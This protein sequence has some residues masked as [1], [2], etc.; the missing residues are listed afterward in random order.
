MGHCKVAGAIARRERRIAILDEPLQGNDGALQAWN[1]PLQLD[2]GSL[3]ARNP[4]F[5]TCNDPL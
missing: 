4:S 1:G 2:N 5:S 3:Q